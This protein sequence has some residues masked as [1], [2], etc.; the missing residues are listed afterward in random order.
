MD[1]VGEKK[2]G[3]RKALRRAEHERR[4]RAEGSVNMGG[5]GEGSEEGRVGEGGPNPVQGTA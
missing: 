1:G 5:V 2:E 4:G 3:V